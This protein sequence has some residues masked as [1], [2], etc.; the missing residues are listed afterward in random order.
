MEQ[1]EL[2]ASTAELLAS[3]C[4][5]VSSSCATA[6]SDPEVS[7]FLHA[8]LGYAWHLRKFVFLCTVGL[9]CRPSLASFRCTGSLMHPPA[10]P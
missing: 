8:V 5:R 4:P 6:A 3:N 7:R 1:D 9:G 2:D 10:Q